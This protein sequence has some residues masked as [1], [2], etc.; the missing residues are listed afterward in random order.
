MDFDIVELFIVFMVFFKFCFDIFKI[1][2]NNKIGELV[3]VFGLYWFVI[4][5]GYVEEEGILV[6]EDLFERVWLDWM[7]LFDFRM[8]KK[9]W[10]DL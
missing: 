3:L 2:G 5:I 1:F 10:N 4:F 9:V 7:I 6:V 8:W